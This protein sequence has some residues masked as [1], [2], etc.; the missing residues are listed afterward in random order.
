MSTESQAQCT[1]LIQQGGLVVA[2]STIVVL[3]GQ[4]RV[5]LELV[6]HIQKGSSMKESQEKLWEAAVSTER[7]TGEVVHLGKVEL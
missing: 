1:L 2:L 3:L 7:S 4:L 5:E 6:Q